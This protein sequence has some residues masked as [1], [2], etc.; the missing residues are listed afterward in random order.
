MRSLL[1][2]PGLMKPPGSDIHRFLP[3]QFVQKGALRKRQLT[4]ELCLTPIV[5][6]LL[7]IVLYLLPTFSASG[8]LLCPCK[9]TDLPAAKNVLE[10]ESAPGVTISRTSV[11]L[12]GDPKADPSELAKQADQP[13]PIAS[14]YADL[15]V[16]KNNYKLLHPSA[17]EWTGL[18]LIEADKNVEF[19]LVRKVLVS[20][21]AAGYHR[22]QLAVEG[23]D[24]LK[25]HRSM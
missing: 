3:L 23:H 12:N 15:L 10:L 1:G 13:I 25:G 9:R 18:V 22:T 20:C 4:V 2:R 17:Q 6:L 21:S 16:L 8:E 19:G 24:P 7:V 11:S 14:L 5:G